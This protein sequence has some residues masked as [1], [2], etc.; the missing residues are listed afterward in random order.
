VEARVLKAVGLD[1]A[2][3]PTVDALV[4]RQVR[5]GGNGRKTEW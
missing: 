4:M 5:E 2:V 3:Y 1:E